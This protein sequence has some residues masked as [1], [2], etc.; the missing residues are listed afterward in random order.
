MEWKEIKENYYEAWFLLGSEKYRDCWD[1][2]NSSIRL[3]YDFF[4]ENKIM[5]DIQ[6]D[7]T[8]AGY[9]EPLFCYALEISVDAF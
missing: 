7:F 1:A 6:V 2:M 9:G 5:I 4:D 3:L 8:R